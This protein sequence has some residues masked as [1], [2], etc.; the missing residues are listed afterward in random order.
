VRPGEVL[1]RGPVRA[2]EESFLY[3]VDRNKDM[4]ISGW[5]AGKLA[6]ST[7]P[8]GIVVLGGL[9]RNAS[10]KV[11]KHELRARYGDSPQNGGS[12]E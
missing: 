2:A 5:T 3:V 11:L 4:I 10:G 12:S 6:S 8:I 1:Y 7:K 9:P